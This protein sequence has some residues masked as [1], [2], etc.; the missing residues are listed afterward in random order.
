VLEHALNFG[1]ARKNVSVHV[2]VLNFGAARK[3]VSARV[4]TL[5]FGATWKNVGVNNHAL[6]LA[7]RGVHTHNNDACGVRNVGTTQWSLVV[8]RAMWVYVVVRQFS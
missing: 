1:A 5:N 8:A 2:C 6:N 3:N 4:F 7:L